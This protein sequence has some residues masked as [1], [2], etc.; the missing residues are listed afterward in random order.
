M[1]ALVVTDPDL[2]TAADSDGHT[3]LAWA[4]IRGQGEVARFLVGAGADPNRVGS[5][6]ASALQWAA[7][8]DDIETVAALLRAGG[9]PTIRDRRGRTPLHVAAR[10]GSIGVAELLLNAGADPNAVTN[11]GW[12]TLSAAYR[13]GHPRMVQLLLDWGADPELLDPE[14]RLPGEISLT[15]PTPIAISRRLADQ[16]VGHYDPGNGSYFEV[17]REGDRMRLLELADDD[18]LPVA[19]DTFY[20]VQE[21]WKVVFRRNARNEVIGMEVISLSHT[22]LA[23]KVVDTSPGLTYI[24]SSACIACHHDD[25]P[26]GG[27][28]GHWIAS[29]HSRAFYSLTTTRAGELAARQEEYGDISDPSR[30]LRCLMCHVTA[31]QNPAAVFADPAIAREGIGCEACHGPG[32]AYVAPEIM[33]DR[34]AFLA[35]GGRIANELTCRQCHRD[36]RFR[37]SP[38]CGT[39]SGTDDEARGHLG[40]LN[41]SRSGA[42]DVQSGR[43]ACGVARPAPA[44]GPVGEARALGLP[45]EERL[46][47]LRAG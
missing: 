37:F 16:Y 19:P 14:G 22:V 42:V 24:G 30:E 41:G 15:R 34:E 44:G 38:P 6:G 47:A 9:N 23:S 12:S 35:H 43:R 28:A 4:G 40:W 3:A 25:G 29:R 1:R 11:E 10:R 2:V 27:P 7:Y 36:E 20:C 5:D 32:S 21:P 45:S 18:M 31:A 17:W 46:L 8:H 26:G 13:G 39:V 33:A